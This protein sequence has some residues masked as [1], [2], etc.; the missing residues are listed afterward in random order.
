MKKSVVVHTVLFSSYPVLFMYA[1][2]VKTLFL[3]DLFPPLFTVVAISI[4]LFITLNALVKNAHRSSLI[5]SL[6][7]LVTLGYGHVFDYLRTTPINSVFHGKQTPGFIVALFIIGMVSYAILRRKSDLSPAVSLCNII[8]LILVSVSVSQIVIF[9]ASYSIIDFKRYRQPQNF[10]IETAD[11]SSKKLPDIYYLIFDRYGRSDT[12]KNVYDFDNSDFISYLKKRG[13]FVPSRSW[14]NY[15]QTYLSLASSLNMQYL[16]SLVEELGQDAQDVRPLAAMIEDYQVLRFLKS[17]G[18]T[19][20]HAGS[21]WA[22][23]ALNRYAYKNINIP[24]LSEFAEIVY[25][26]TLL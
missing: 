25:S 16:D 21:W 10:N 15:T 22:P 6:V 14:A 26:R 7:M 24:S 19:Y 4:G 2:N 23:T 5:V 13:F 11:A 9:Y 20:I 3:S 1:N 8:S 17:R 12:L 18:Y